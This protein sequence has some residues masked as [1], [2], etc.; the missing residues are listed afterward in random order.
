[1]ATIMT[2]EF[3]VSYP[4]VFKAKRNEL[5]G[6]DEFS[7]QALFSKDADLSKLQA[8][9]QQTIVDK[10]GADPKKHPKNLRKPFRNQ[11]DKTK[12]DDATGKDY[13]PEPY[14][15]G[16]VYLNLK[17]SQRPG[18]VDAAV[19]PII[20][21]SEFYAGCYARATVSAY[22]YEQKGNCGVSLGLRNIQKVRDGDALGSKTRAEDDFTPISGVK[23]TDALF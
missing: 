23:N 19:Q 22:A 2:P 11:A 16:A 7:V 4:S 9:V 1:M 10:W 21:E 13:L 8:L 12:T 6:K 17:S 20:D 18:V 15:S 14:V 3:R 5:N